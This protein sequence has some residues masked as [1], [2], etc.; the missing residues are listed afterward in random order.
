MLSCGAEPSCLIEI[1]GE[2]SAITVAS[3][4]ASVAVPGLVITSWVVEAR[5]STGPSLDRRLLLLAKAVR[6]C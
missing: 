3:L 4:D 1:R 5:R 2:F 6:A